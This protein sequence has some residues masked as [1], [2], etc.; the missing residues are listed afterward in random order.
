MRYSLDV[1]SSFQDQI[2]NL[3][4]S[5]VKDSLKMDSSMRTPILEPEQVVPAYLRNQA[6]K[7]AEPVKVSKPELARSDSSAFNLNAKVTIPGN[8]FFHNSLSSFKSEQKKTAVYLET[9]IEDEQFDSQSGDSLP[10]SIAD[11]T[12]RKVE[13]ESIV[14]ESLE[15][16]P[17]NEVVKVRH[18]SSFDGHKEWISGLIILVLII[19]GFVRISFYKYLYDLFSAVRFQ[20]SALKL[21][22]TVNVQN[23]K[24]VFAL[25]ALFF[26]STALMVFEF[27]LSFGQA[28]LQLE[29]I[30]LFGVILGGLLLYFLIKQLMYRFVSVVFEVQ[31]QTG[32]YLFNAGLLSQ[33]YGL[34]LLPIVCLVP[35]V[36]AG[37]GTFLLKIG[38]AL[39]LFM[40]VIQLVRGAKI[41]LRTPLSIF[42]MFLYFCALEILPLSLLIKVLMF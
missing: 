8:Y 13:Q 20:Q 29:G 27:V 12:S 23:N 31:G 34:I 17:K 22:S 42:Y 30:Y 5:D 35:F 3:Q 10:L 21:Y 33:V 38:V 15:V 39:F 40:Y 6:L 36:D 32:E 19:A 11:S 2:I 41:I 16:R 25:T 18:T 28:N 7:K 1:Y 37:T 4:Q 14:R 9:T 26:I 24:P